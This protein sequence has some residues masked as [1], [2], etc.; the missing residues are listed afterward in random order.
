[1]RSTAARALQCIPPALIAFLL[2]GC[3]T[4]RSAF[5]VIGEERL[6]SVNETD[7]PF[8][9][10]GSDKSAVV[11]QGA[12]GGKNFFRFPSSGEVSLQGSLVEDFRMEF[13]ARLEAPVEHEIATAMVNFRNYFNRRYCLIIEPETVRLTA[14]R[15]THSNLADLSRY[16]TE[17]PLNAWNRFEIVAVGPI[18]KIFKNDALIMDIVD[19]EYVE[20][21]GNIVFE[22]HSKYSFRDVAVSRVVDF[23][24]TETPRPMTAA[25]AATPA[26]R[27]KLLVAVSSFEAKGL[28]S[29]KASLITDLFSS[30]LLST[31]V[32]RVVER[33][34]I[35]KILAEQEFQLSDIADAKTAVAV[36]NILNAEYLTS[37]S[38]GLLGG[39]YV[40]TV[41]LMRVKTGETLVSA[42]RSYAQA[43]KIPDGI[44]A[45]CEEIA[46]KITA[47]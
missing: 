6:F 38:I 10:M 14:A 17:I 30:A 37:G 40:V 24:K 26:P 4:P 35:A 19:K 3:L 22:S 13:E 36:G 31:G 8:A 42:Q 32:F 41:R 28:E 43:E 12:D 27:E 23:K 16:S 2:L 15:V 18:L 29:S 39:Q 11:V 25:A 34:Q 5:T 45:L 9:W 20:G 46:K 7:N 33:S 44:A 1:M 21:K 47:G